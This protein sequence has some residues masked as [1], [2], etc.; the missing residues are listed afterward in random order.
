ML[1]KKIH[2]GSGFVTTTA[3]NTEI[4]EFE[5]KIPDANGLVTATVLT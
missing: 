4:T 2:G 1:I 5:N 3:L